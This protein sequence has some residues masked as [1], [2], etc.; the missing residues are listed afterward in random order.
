MWWYL[1][2]D[3]V[4]IKHIV[5]SNIHLPKLMLPVLR[6]SL[7]PSVS[8]LGLKI[9]RSK[10]ITF[11]YVFSELLVTR[12]K[13]LS[14]RLKIYLCYIV[15]RLPSLCLWSFFTPRFMLLKFSVNRLLT[16][17]AEKTVHNLNSQILNAR[18]THR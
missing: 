8:R 5:H 18:R 6:L 16:V 4:E 14:Y 1:T 3:K 12:Q 2:C 17:N 10:S 11:T 15:W 13:K 7:I 9:R